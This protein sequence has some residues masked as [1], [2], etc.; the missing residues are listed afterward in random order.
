MKFVIVA[1]QY[2]EN[3]GG[4]LVLHKLCHLLNTLGYQAWLFPYTSSVGHSFNE[5][6]LETKR[7]LKRFFFPYNTN[8]SFNTPL[9][10]FKKDIPSDAVVIYPEIVS[11]NPLHASKVVRWFLHNP[12]YHTGSIDYGK[13]EFYIAYK[14]FG[15]EAKYSDSYLAKTELTVTHFFDELYNDK[16]AK[17]FT[18]RTGSA[19]CLR[20]GAG[21]DLV[22]DVDDSILIDG[23]T[24]YEIAEIFKK[25][26]YFYCY[27]PYTAYFWFAISCGC[28][29]II[30]PLENISKY[31]WYP[32][33]EDRLGLSYGMDD[34]EYAI[35]TRQ[36]ALVKFSKQEQT[37]IVN[38]KH[39]IEE[40]NTY[41]SNGY[42]NDFE[43]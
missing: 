9:L 2:D 7:W 34:I 17:D 10:R 25:V 24:H 42:R 18:E 43:K 35:K 6:V 32:N 38:V 39:F 27:D 41:Y 29:P 30:I 22:H 19:Y 1:P 20:K 11:G 40:L 37:N 33:E 4:A 26:K 8:S 28:I 12:G 5:K 15:R 13:D 21:R 36:Q 23:M 14:S 16:D 3:K 31:E